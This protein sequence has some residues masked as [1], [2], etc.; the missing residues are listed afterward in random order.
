MYDIKKNVY[1]IWSFNVIYKNK[2]YILFEVLSLLFLDI[3]KNKM[4]K[5]LIFLYVFKNKMWII[6]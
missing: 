2:M 6:F 1:F 3:F 4:G 5:S